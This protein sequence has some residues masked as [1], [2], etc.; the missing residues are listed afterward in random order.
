M[1]RGSKMR[2]MTKP[3]G[4]LIWEVIER[5]WVMLEKGAM[6]TPEGTAV[7]IHTGRFGAAVRERVLAIGAPGIRQPFIRVY[8]DEQVEVAEDLTRDLIEEV[9]VEFRKAMILEDLAS[10]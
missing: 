5:A 1:S 9:L 10:A 4:S 2:V 3:E 6:P 8:P 7:F